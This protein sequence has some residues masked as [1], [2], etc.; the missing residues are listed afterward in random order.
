MSKEE[1][2]VEGSHEMVIL[3]IDSCHFVTRKQIRK[4]NCRGKLAKIN[5][6]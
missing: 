2:Q 6:D 1:Y 5:N 4:R 3:F